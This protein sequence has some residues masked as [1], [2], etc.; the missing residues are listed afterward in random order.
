MAIIQKETSNGRALGVW[1]IEEDENELLSQTIGLDGI[2]DKLRHPNRRLEFVAGRALVRHLMQELGEPFEGVTSNEHGKPIIKNSSCQVSLTHSFPY[3]ASLV[4]VDKPAGIDLELVNYRL[5]KMAP[6]LFHVSELRDAGRNPVKHTIIWS[7]KETLMKIY[8]KR[9]VVFSEHLRIEPF[10]LNKEGG[11][12]I[13]HI[14]IE[15]AEARIPLAYRLID[16]YV[17]VFTR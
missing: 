13:G 2:P 14:L 6:R 8:G 17:L 10:N 9:D 5:L 7:G 15:G 12:L 1:K 11:E 3:V 4:D 16:N